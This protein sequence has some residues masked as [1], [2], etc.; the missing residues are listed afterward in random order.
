MMDPDTG[1]GRVRKG[2]HGQKRMIR[3]IEPRLCKLAFER[4]LLRE[5]LFVQF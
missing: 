3:Q 1:P 2:G 5:G 4:L